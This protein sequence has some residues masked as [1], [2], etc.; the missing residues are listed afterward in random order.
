MINCSCGAYNSVSRQ[1]LSIAVSVS[2]GGYFEIFVIFISHRANFE[3]RL[4]YD[5]RTMYA[6]QGM[7]RLQFTIKRHVTDGPD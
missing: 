1:G 2:T 3:I 6:L 5:A 4:G 7:Q